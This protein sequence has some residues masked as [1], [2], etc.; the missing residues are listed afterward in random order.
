MFE[1]LKR[2][3]CK[4]KKVKKETTTPEPKS[5]EGAQPKADKP[6]EQSKEQKQGPS[7]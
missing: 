3:F 7:A 6:E 5:Q 4:S 2:I 1:F